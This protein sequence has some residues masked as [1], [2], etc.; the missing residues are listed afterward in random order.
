MSESQPPLRPANAVSD[1]PDE[2]ARAPAARRI[3]N[4][5]QRDA[6]T[7]VQTADETAGASSVLELE[8]AP[9]GGNFLHYHTTFA[10]QF[11]VVSGE[12]GV[13]VG[14]DTFTLKPGET[15]VAP[16]RSVHRWFNTT[17]QPAI[18]RVDLRP[19]SPGFERALQ[20]AYGLARDG[21][22]DQKG[23]PKSLVHKAL[24]VDLS[25]TN[26]PGVFSVLAPL[27]RLIATR[28]RRQGVLRELEARYCR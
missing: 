24:L 2:S 25:D 19:G 28:A 17:Q 12:F 7:F 16:V 14:K 20:I 1:A 11:T 10:E 18:V 4:P 13:Q 8:V 5:V 3:F 22:T 9:G 27:L 15:A 21:L 26:V 6:A 23:L